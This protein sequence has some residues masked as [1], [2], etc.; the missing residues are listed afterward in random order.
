[1]IKHLRIMALI[2]IFAITAG[3]QT[4]QSTSASGAMAADAQM[5][6]EAK[7]A[8]KSLYISTPQA[9]V[10]A[11]RAKGILVFPDVLKAGLIVGAQH[12]E[13]ELIENGKVTGY[14]STTAASYGLQAGAQKF[15][16]AMFFMTSSALND[17]KTGNGFEVGVGPS[18][19]V[20]DSGMAKSLT[21]STLQSDIYAFIFDQ[22]GLMAGLGLQGSKITKLNR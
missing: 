11:Q 20:V 22:K 13:G 5:D 21:T 3:C 6:Q 14:Y 7:A 18:I 19:V 4:D 10:L 17:L 15:G 2:S 9:R 12:G 1:M 8:L 16:Y